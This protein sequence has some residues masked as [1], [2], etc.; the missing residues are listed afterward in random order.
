[1]RKVNALPAPTPTKKLIDFRKTTERRKNKKNAERLWRGFEPGPVKLRPKPGCRAHRHMVGIASSCKGS[2]SVAAAGSK[3]LGKRSHPGRTAG[4]GAVA[5][6]ATKRKR[7]AAAKMQVGTLGELRQSANLSSLALQRWL[8]KIVHGGRVVT[9]Q[10]ITH[11]VFPTKDAAELFLADSFKKKHQDM[12]E[13]LR[14]ACERAATWKEAMKASK[15]KGCV[16]ISK[17]CDVQTFLSECLTLPTAG[18]VH[19]SFLE[20]PKLFQGGV[21]RYGRP[22]AESKRRRVV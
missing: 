8:Q 16:T 7:M 2:E 4:V 15:K 3:W 6:A 9:K 22:L 14:K 12:T 13:A 18:G 1:M 5:T 21:G 17:L 20:K 11:E 19:T 10:G